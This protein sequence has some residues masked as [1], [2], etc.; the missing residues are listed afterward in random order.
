[1]VLSRAAVV[2]TAGD[3][4]HP[5]LFYFI[6]SVVFPATSAFPTVFCGDC[7]ERPFIASGILPLNGDLVRAYCFL[8]RGPADALAYS[9]E[10]LFYL[11]LP[12]MFGFMVLSLSVALTRCMQSPLLALQAPQGVP[13]CTS[14]CGSSNV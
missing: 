5:S 13:E 6:N 1:M 3:H 9:V 8:T 12:H 14:P 10:I 4:R 11:N 7:G 2:N